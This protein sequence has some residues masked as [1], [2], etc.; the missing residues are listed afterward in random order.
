[1]RNAGSDN[2]A[3]P[4]VKADG[5]KHNRKDGQPIPCISE[6]KVG[7]ILYNYRVKV[8]QQIYLKQA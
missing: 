1:M 5:Q 6:T 4:S 2:M 3:M 8:G 7:L